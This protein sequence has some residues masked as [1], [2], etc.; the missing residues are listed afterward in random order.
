MAGD[1]KAASMQVMLSSVACGSMECGMNANRSPAWPKLWRLKTRAIPVSPARSAISNM[2]LL[3][4]LPLHRT[5][6]SLVQETASCSGRASPWLP[7]PG[8]QRVGTSRCSV[9]GQPCRR[10]VLRRAE[11]SRDPRSGSS[12]PSSGGPATSNPQQPWA[13]N[14]QY[15]P[16]PSAEQ[17][18]RLPPNNGGPGSG[19]SGGGDGNGLSNI[20]KAFIAGSFILGGWVAVLSCPPAGG[21][22]RKLTRRWH[23]S[24]TAAPPFVLSGSCSS[25]HDAPATA[26]K[27]QLHACRAAGMGAGIWFSS[28]VT[29]E[30]QNMA[31][32]Q[33]IDNKT[34]NSEICMAN[35]YSS[36]VFDQRIFVSFNP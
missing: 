27:L 33:L 24:C 22:T 18:P 3:L 35:G 9:L 2:P 32:T 14:Y 4:S 34:P 20:V 16:Q 5:A 26:V 36:M 25:L 28:E 29:F 1:S 23:T 21:T 8:L 15:A 31:S 30:P 7:P 10:Q 11:F 19:P 12:G 6:A 17:P 13:E